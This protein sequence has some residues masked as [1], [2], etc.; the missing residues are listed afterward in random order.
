[1]RRLILW[2]I[3]VATGLSNCSLAQERGLMA[4]DAK[5]NGQSVRL[6]FDTGAELTVLFESTAKR[7]GLEVQPPSTDVQPAPGKIKVGFTEECRFHFAGHTWPM[8]FAVADLPGFLKPGTDGLIG[9][10][11]IKD[12]VIEIRHNPNK[13]RIRGELGIDPTQWSC[14]PLRP[15]SNR[16]IMQIPRSDGGHAQVLIDTGAASGV[17]L[18]QSRWRHSAHSQWPS[19]LS[20]VYIMGRG[21]LVLE[22][23]WAK[24][25]VFEGLTFTEVPVS[26]GIAP[27]TGMVEGRLDAVFGLY[28]ISCFSWVI[29]GPANKVYIKPNDVMRTPQKY[30][31]NRLGAVFV[32]RDLRTTNALLA[33]VVESSPAYKAGIRPGDELLRIN[34]VDATRWRTNP[35]VM[36]LSR[37]WD[38]PA[39]TELNLVIQREGQKRQITVTL[40][41]I[42]ER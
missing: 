29:D 35:S 24:E 14:F 2:L 30:R 4:F 22:E 26:Q 7:L 6:A 34:G 1:M 8:R 25:L 31:Y 28:A 21:L 27:E 32:P 19:T 41:E 12:N 38:Q 33:H 20:A 13:L 11:S 39:S 10:G 23:S 36:P 18:T 42:F 5:I 40:E 3:V 9:W 16:V 37:F 15:D 17:G